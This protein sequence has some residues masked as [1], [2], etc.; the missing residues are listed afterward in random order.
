[1]YKQNKCTCNTKFLQHN[2]N[3]KKQK[4]KTKNSHSFTLKIIT[5]IFKIDNHGKKNPSF[6]TIKIKR[7]ML[8]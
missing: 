3:L 8:L 6:I 2:K 7:S 4:Q 5:K 1:M